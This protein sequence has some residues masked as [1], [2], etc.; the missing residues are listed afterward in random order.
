[1]LSATQRSAAIWSSRPQLRARLV[2]AA[3]ETGMAQPAEAAEAIVERDHD[4]VGLA[5]QPGPVVQARRPV[6]DR[7]AATVQPHEHRPL[8][9]NAGVKTLRFRHSSAVA[10]TGPWVN[11][12]TARWG[13]GA[14][15]PATS[16]SRTPVHVGTGVGG[17]QRGACA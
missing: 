16:A 15:G 10:G 2:G 1:M 12:A 7:E 6:A 11:S 9:V 5:G 13:W 8:A 4:G 14:A 17:A 3:A